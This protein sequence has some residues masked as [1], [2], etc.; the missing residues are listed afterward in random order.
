MALIN[1]NEYGWSDIKLNLLGR[2]VEGIMSIEYSDTR[3]KTNNYGKGSR[4]VSRGKGKY[5]AKCKITLSMKEVEAVQRL[6]PKGAIIQD[7]PM[8]DINVAFDPEDGSSPIVRDRIR[9]AEFTN[10]ERKVKIGGGEIAH[11]FEIIVS[12]IDWNI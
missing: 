11:E 3:E 2:T 12:E 5:E 1:G 6:L 10:K 9:Q 7:I 4:P 8:F